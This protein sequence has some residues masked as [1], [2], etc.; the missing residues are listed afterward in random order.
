MKMGISSTAMVTA[1]EARRM[2][3]DFM[4]EKRKRIIEANAKI[5]SDDN[6]ER[7][8]NRMNTNEFVNYK[9][10]TQEEIDSEE[11]FWKELGRSK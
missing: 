4:L 10:G 1:A 7:E 9:I 8:L 6:I 3:V 11:A 2:W 5:M